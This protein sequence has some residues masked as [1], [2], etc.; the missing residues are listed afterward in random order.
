MFTKKEPEGFFA[1]Q[2]KKHE[3]YRKKQKDDTG[4]QKMIVAV[5]AF[6]AFLYSSSLFYL[7]HMRWKQSSEANTYACDYNG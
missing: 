6:L 5:C 4:S 3:E 2:K 1:V 7:T